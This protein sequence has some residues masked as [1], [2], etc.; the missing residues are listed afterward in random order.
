M[1]S[2]LVTLAFLFVTF[3]PRINT[4]LKVC[5]LCGLI[6]LMQFFL[7]P[8]PTYTPII[9]TSPLRKPY[10]RTPSSAAVACPSITVAYRSPPLPLCPVATLIYASLSLSA[11]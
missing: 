5:S 9:I 1:D 3:S 10:T 7:W 11:W 2:Q 4:L 8:T 6:S